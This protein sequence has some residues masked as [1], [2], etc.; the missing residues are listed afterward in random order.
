[1]LGEGGADEVW[2]IEEVE[3]EGHT[4]GDGGAMGIQE[5]PG[6]RLLEF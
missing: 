3:W 6:T 4:S 2:T 1:M 5:E